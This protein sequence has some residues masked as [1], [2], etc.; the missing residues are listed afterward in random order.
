MITPAKMA[1]PP[2]FGVG[3][4]CDVRPL[5][6]AISFF[7]LETLTREGIAKKVTQKEKMIAI[8]IRI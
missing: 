1:T 2:R 3:V 7:I 5:G 8:P 6:W 4:M